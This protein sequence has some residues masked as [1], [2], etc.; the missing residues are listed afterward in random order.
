MQHIHIPSPQLCYSYI[1]TIFTSVFTSAL[2]ENTHDLC[3]NINYPYHILEFC[4]H[5][6]FIKKTILQCIMSCV[7]WF[8]IL[9]SHNLI[10]TKLFVWLIFHDLL[11]FHPKWVKVK[12]LVCMTMKVFMKPS[13]IFQQSEDTICFYFIL[14][15]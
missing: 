11:S 7:L 14:F 6:Y 13:L 15:C 12:I 3:K 9:I 1:Y 4:W 8:Q 5:N 10:A 2:F